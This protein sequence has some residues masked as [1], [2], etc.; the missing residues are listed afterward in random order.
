VFAYEEGCTLQEYLE[1]NPLISVEFAHHLAHHMEKALHGF[2]DLGILHRDIKPDNIFLQKDTWL[3]KVFDFSD[4]IFTDNQIL[5]SPQAEFTGSPKYAHPS[6]R[7]LHVSFSPVIFRIEFDMY[8]MGVIL[9]D[10]I[11]P[12]VRRIADKGEVLALA[13]YFFDSSQWS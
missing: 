13:H 3:P 1:L 5:N 2:H 10:D 6:V 7:K 12:R 8:A 4:A 11:A 9:R